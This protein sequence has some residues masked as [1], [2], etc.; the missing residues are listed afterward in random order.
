MLGHFKLKERKIKQEKIN[1]LLLEY[2]ATVCLL[3]EGGLNG[4]D[5]RPSK[6]EVSACSIVTPTKRYNYN[7][8]DNSTTI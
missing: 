3:K 5:V 8:K 6:T 7:T 1:M 2:N 4:F